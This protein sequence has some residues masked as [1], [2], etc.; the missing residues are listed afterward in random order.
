MD[1]PE[2]PTSAA[3]MGNAMTHDAA[4]Q[5]IAG[6][7]PAKRGS[8]RPRLRNKWRM[9][10]LK[11]SGY[12]GM[13]RLAAWLASR[14]S[15]PFH[16]TCYL[17]DLVP[18]GFVA[19]GARITHPG[20]RLGGN[21]YLGHGCVIYS[22]NR[23]GPVELADRVQIYGNTFIETGQGG[24]IRIGEGT[25][26]QPGCHIHAYLSGIHIGKKVEIAPGCGF[27]CYDHGMATEIPIMNQPLI[28]QGDITVGDGAWIGYGVTVLQ[29]V[30]I[31][32]GAVVAAGAVVTRD[33][34]A[35]AIAGG[36]P[37]KV[38]KMRS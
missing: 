16:Q 17:A 27:Y 26:I 12:R 35:N 14:H 38:L 19:P 5:P 36:V 22:T 37:A 28:S 18:Q 10:W 9:F 33:V 8:I 11:R 31:G 7:N 29:G 13:G 24:I 6:P 20:L 23:G 25:H 34:P 32:E 2:P 30:T 1:K 4:N 15:A 21:V 3:A